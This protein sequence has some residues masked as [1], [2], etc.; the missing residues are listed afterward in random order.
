MPELY[1]QI[2]LTVIQLNSQFNFINHH[3]KMCLLK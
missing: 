2:K 1:N 3:L